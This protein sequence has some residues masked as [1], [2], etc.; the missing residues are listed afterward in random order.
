MHP[1]HIHGY[2]A[3]Q[4]G[5]GD[6]VYD[7]ETDVSNYNLENPMRRDTFTLL[8]FGWTAIRFRASNVGVWP[9][10]C[11]MTVRESFFFLF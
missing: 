10:H 5:M 4:V 1:F 7:E 6:G 2:S 8:P 9:W 11:T 3:F